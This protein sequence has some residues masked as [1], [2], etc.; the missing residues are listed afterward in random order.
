MGSRGIRNGVIRR[1]GLAVVA[2]AVW[3]APAAQAQTDLQDRLE[4]WRCF[5]NT[6]FN[7]TNALLTLR[8]LPKAYGEVSVAGTTHPASFKVAG[9]DRRWDFGHDTTANGLWPY[10]FLIKPDGTGV[11]YDFSLSTDGTAKPSQI[12]QC[13]QSQAGE[14]AWPTGQERSPTNTFRDPLRSGR[15]GPEMVVIPAGSFWMGC[16]SGVRCRTSGN[17]Y[18]VH[19]VTIPQAFAVGKYEVTFA[20]WDACVS[21]G[22]CSHRPDD[23]GLGRGRHPVA[24]V[25]WSDAQDYVR[26]LSSETAAEYRLLS[27]SEWEYAARAGSVTAYSWGNTIQYGLAHCYGCSDISSR[28]DDRSLH[29]GSFA[30][31]A[32]GLHDMHGNVWEWVEDCWNEN[33]AGAPSDGGAWLSGVCSRRVL[34][35]GAWDFSPKYHLRSA[36]RGVN[37]SD[38]RHY[39]HGFRVA[40]TLTSRK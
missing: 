20:E 27:E 38:R 1:A 35:G 39:F 21:A 16:V 22:G 8:R 9:L 33:Y 23:R 32:W 5:D 13:E 19:Q 7:R 25:S 31:N 30:A 36:Y 10:A 11:Y 3:L 26:W 34:R 37:V 17:E 6:D 40:R 14:A 24:N 2:V 15:S 29:V 4:T 18:P 12:F 28:F